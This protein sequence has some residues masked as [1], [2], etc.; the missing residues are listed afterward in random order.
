MLQKVG[1]EPDAS[2]VSTSERMTECTSENCGSTQIASEQ[3]NS[4]CC[5]AQFSKQ[6]ITNHGVVCICNLIIM[7]QGMCINLLRLTPQMSCSTLHT[8]CSIGG[9][10][11]V[12][13]VCNL[14]HS[15]AYFAC[16]IMWRQLTM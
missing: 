9:N 12:Y 15:F 11:L 10:S 8:A 4:S 6:L 16:F 14:I 5:R 1:R 13:A 3:N 7:V 2:H